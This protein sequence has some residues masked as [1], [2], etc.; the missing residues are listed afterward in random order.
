MHEHQTTAAGDLQ[1]SINYMV[2]MAERPARYLGGRTD[3]APELNWRL[4]ARPVKVRV[5]RSVQPALSLETDGLMMCRAETAVTDFYDPANIT[6]I[7]YPEVERLVRDLT[8]ARE[9]VAFDNNLRSSAKDRRRET[10][11]FPPGRFA[12]GD[13]TSKSSAQRIRDLLPAKEAEVRLAARYAFINVWRP[14]GGAVQNDA[15]AV[16]DAR[17]VAR[18]DLVATDLIY[19]ERTGEIFNITFNPA[20]RWY[21]FRHLDPNEVLVF[22]NF[23][24][25]S[26]R[27]VPHS[28]FSDPT[29]ATD[30]PPRESIEVRVIAFY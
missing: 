27:V 26:G 17:S 5:G 22:V 20:H 4:E 25:A 11:A 9:V 21:Y 28:S 24:S 2:A 13:Y 23:D 1:T 18:E 10:G 6:N 19:P 12:H 30:A 29:A 3:G 8:G 7:Y 16:C 15:L 14:L